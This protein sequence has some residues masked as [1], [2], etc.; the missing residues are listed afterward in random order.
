MA[1]GLVT[2]QRREIEAC[3]FAVEGNNSNISENIWAEPKKTPKPF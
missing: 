2:W 1:E 3:L